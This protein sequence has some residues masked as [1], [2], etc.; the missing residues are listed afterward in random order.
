M[1]HLLVNITLSLILLI[2]KYGT[3]VAVSQ[4]GINMIF[5]RKNS[6]IFTAVIFMAEG[7]RS[8]KQYDLHKEYTN[9]HVLQQ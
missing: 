5:R 1:I 9:S 8:I 6:V 7:P 2:E 3:P 4:N